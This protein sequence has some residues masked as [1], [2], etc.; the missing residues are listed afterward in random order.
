MKHKV[1]IEDFEPIKYELASLIGKDSN[2]RL[3]ATVDC[4]EGDIVFRGYSLGSLHDV[5][6]SFSQAIQ[7]YNTL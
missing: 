7:T 4:A 1:K 2:K 3:I 5:T 6:M